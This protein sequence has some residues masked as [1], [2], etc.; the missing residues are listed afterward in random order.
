M[1]AKNDS[2]NVQKNHEYILIYRKKIILDGFKVKATLLRNEKKEKDV[3]EEDGEFYYLND[4]ITT[5][6]EGGILNARPNLGYT[7]YYNPETKEKIAIEDYDKHLSL[8]FHF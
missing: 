2:L 6:G 8:F 7:I 5:R 1:N 4:S 3:F